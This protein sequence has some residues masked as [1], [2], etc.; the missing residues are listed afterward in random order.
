MIITSYTQYCYNVLRK[1]FSLR[2]SYS[3]V[4]N[5]LNSRMETGDEDGEVTARSGA[6]HHSAGG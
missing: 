1:K 4:R 5:A 2:L 3:E 6:L